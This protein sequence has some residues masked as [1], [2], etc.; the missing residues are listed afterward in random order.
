MIQDRQ[1][2]YELREARSEI[3]RH[4]TLIVEL[5]DGLEW[6][7][8]MIAWAETPDEIFHL[9]GEDRKRYESLR[10]ILDRQVS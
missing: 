5:R 7:L 9:V 6:A 8:A 10:L 1:A 2:Q 3:A 4:H